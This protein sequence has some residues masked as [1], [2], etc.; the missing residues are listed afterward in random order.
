MPDMLHSTST[1]GRPFGSS[2]SR[3]ISSYRATRPGALLHRAR[4]DELQHDTHRLALRLMASKPQRFTETVSGYAPSLAAR[5][6][7]SN[8]R[9]MRLPR[10]AAAGL[11]MRYGSSAWMLRPV[12]S[13]PGPSRPAARRPGRYSPFQSPQAP[14]ASS[15]VFRRS[16]SR[17]SR[18]SSS[19][20]SEP[21]RA[22]SAAEPGTATSAASAR[23]SDARSASTSSPRRARAAPPLASPPRPSPVVRPEVL[24]GG[25]VRG[26]AAEHVQ[27]LG[28]EPVLQHAEVREQ[29]A[30][31][32]LERCR[33]DERL[34]RRRVF[35]RTRF[36][37][38]REPFFGVLRHEP[39]RLG[40][41]PRRR[42]PVFLSLV[43][44]ASRKRHVRVQPRG[45]HQVEHRPREREEVGVRRLAVL[46]EQ[47]AQ[48]GGLAVQTGAA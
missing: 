28:E 48:L 47:L 40:G 8:A 42:R 4:A 25:L 11:G 43:L 12:G 14:A 39:R 18:A 1:R 20:A 27:P 38:R 7:A 30:R 6:C 41:D 32:R 34:R 45:R 21:E 29:L 17:I 35:G 19:R 44:R 15:S 13:T 37:V 22:W 10:S 9:A 23:S 46:R 24:L 31:V 36:F 2:S 33:G 16:S 5:C 26:R 3:G